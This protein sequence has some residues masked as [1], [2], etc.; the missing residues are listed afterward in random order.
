[1]QP[2]SACEQQEALDAALRGGLGALKAYATECA[3]APNGAQAQAEVARRE[4]DAFA[5]RTGNGVYLARS[6]CLATPVAVAA[7][8]LQG[9]FPALA[10][11]L[12]RLYG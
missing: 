3:K 10:E 7:D 4:A 6:L 11:R 5:V 8:L 12:R 1:M 9:A 2:P